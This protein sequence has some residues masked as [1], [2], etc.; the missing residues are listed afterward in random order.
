LKFLYGYTFYIPIVDYRYYLEFSN[1]L[2][3]N[4]DY[5]YRHCISY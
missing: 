5:F 4:I 1:K 3:Y 2:L